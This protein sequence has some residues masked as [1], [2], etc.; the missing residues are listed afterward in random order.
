[1]RAPVAEP[2]ADRLLVEDDLNKVELTL[3]TLQRHH[4]M[5]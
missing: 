2:V 4:L 3:R 1:M 5:H